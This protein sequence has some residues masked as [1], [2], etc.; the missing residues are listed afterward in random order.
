MPESSA[1][2]DIQRWGH[3]ND[4]DDI[5]EE[6]VVVHNELYISENDEEEILDHDDED[7]DHHMGHGDT[8]TWSRQ[9]DMRSQGHEDTQIVEVEILDE[10]IEDHDVITK[11]DQAQPNYKAQPK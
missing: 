6:H 4:H 1:W 8:G 3:Y 7:D 11:D 2:P 10:L 9:K 5:S